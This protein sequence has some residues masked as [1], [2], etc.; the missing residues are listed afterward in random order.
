MAEFKL[1]RIKFVYQGAWTASTSYVVDDVVTVGG[2]S[3]IC[4]ITNTSSSTFATDLNNVTPYWSLMSDGQQ[5]RGNWTNTT[6]YN[7]GDLTQ[8][9]GIVYLC[10]TGHTSAA[11][12]LS[13]TATTFTVS[14]GTA[15]LGFATQSGGAPFVVG[16]TI[17]LAG[18][19]PA[20]TSGSVNTV[21][22]SFIVV[23]CTSTQLTFALTG[24]YTVATLGTVSGTSGVESQI[25][26]W[27]AFAS[28]LNWLG[29]W[30]TSTRYKVD[31]FIYYG[32]I[33]YICN[34]AHVSAS[35][36]ASVG[37]G[38][39][40]N[41]SLWSVFNSGLNYIGLWSGSSVRYKLN[42]IVKYGADLWICTTQHTSTGTTIN[43]SNFTLF[44]NGFEFMNSYSA[45]NSYIIGD[46]VTYGG[47][48]YTCIQNHASGS[49]QTPSTATGYWQIFTTGLNYAG[50][51]LTG[52]SY[53]IG[54]IVTLGGYSYVATADNSA[55]QPPS[56]NWSQLN[57]GI[58]WNAAPQTVYSNVAS[59]N[60]SSS[61]TGSPT[62]TITRN[63]TAYSAV[64]G[65]A[66]GTGY[67]INDTLTITGTVLGGTVANNLVVKVAT[68]SGSAIATV[69]VVSGYAATWKTGIVYV[70]GDAV[71]YGNSSFICVSA[72]IGSTGV[73]DPG[74]DTTATYWNILAGGAD[75][76]VLTTKGDMVYYGTNGPTRLPIGTDGQVLRV[77]N[78]V[79][80]WSYYGLLQN[81]VYVAQNG[82]DASG[83]GQGLTIDK[84]WATLLYACKQI[85]D[86]YLNG[87][88][89]KA[90]TINKQFILK[91]VNTFILT[92]YSFNVTGTAA[93]GNLINV[94]GSSTSSQTTT[95]NMYYGMPI[96]FSA[97][98][99]GLTVGTIYYVNTFP[100]ATTFTVSTSYRSGATLGIVSNSAVA[101]TATFSYTQS[102]AERDAGTILD[103]IT[104]DLTHGGNLYVTNATQQFFKTLTSLITDNAT[105]EV[106]VWIAS[107][108]YM[109]NTLLP[110]VLTNSAPATNYQ[111]LQNIPAANRAI[112]NTTGVT[113][114]TIES[115]SL[116]T[117][118]TLMEVIV[119]ALTAGTYA[120]IPQ[121]NR[122]HTSIYLKTGTYN[123]Y[124][125]IV[126]S[127]DTAI[128]GDELRST[129]V[130]ASTAQPYLGNDK[131]RTVASLKRI[132]ANLPALVSNAPI[133]TAT[134]L[135][136]YSQS[137]LNNSTPSF[138]TA[139]QSIITNSG[140]IQTILSGGLTSVPGYAT[141]SITT[142]LP[143]TYT[144]LGTGT[145]TLSTPTGFG[146][147]LTNTAYSITGLAVS[148]YTGNVTGATTGYDSAVTNIS[149]NTTFLQTE[150]AAYLETYNSGGWTPT[151]W[152]NLST[153]QKG[154]TLR[155]IAYLLQSVK[156]D[157]TYGGNSQ[158]QIDG[159][160]YWSLGNNT[161][162]TAAIIA[163]TTAALTRLQTIIP[164]IINGTTA[165]WTKST[166]NGASQVLSVIGPFANAALYAQAL[167]GN[168]INWLNGTNSPANGGSL[169]TGASLS[170]T[171]QPYYGW[172][173]LAQ[174]NA[175]AAIQQ[176]KT[177]IQLQIQNYVAVTYPNVVSNLALTYRDAGTIVDALSYDMV[178]GT[179]Y[180]SMVSGRAF[181][182]FNTSA[183]TL[184]GTSSGELQATTTSINYITNYLNTITINSGGVQ[185][186]GGDVGNEP[187]VNLVINNIKIIQDMFAGGGVITGPNNPNYSLGLIHQPAFN[188][189]AVSNY[190]TYYLVGYADAKAQ[191]VQ[192]Y[193][194]IKDEI[195]NY[196]NNTLTGTTWA[197]YGPLYQ[198]ETVRDLSS[199]LDALQYDL[200]Y[201]C[202]N[203]ALIVGNSYYSLNTALIVIPYTTGVLAA[204]NR[205]SAI[206]PYVLDPTDNGTASAAS[207]V[208][209]GN[210]T[211]QVTSGTSGSPAA[212]KFA[213][214]RVADIIYFLNNNGFPNT[215]TG[216]TT[217]TISGTTLTVTSGTGL[218]IGQ[219]ITGTTLSTTI[220]GT[221]SNGNVTISSTTGLASGMAITFST[222]Y[223]YGNQFAFGGLTQTTYTINTVSTGV[224]TLYN[225]GTT[226][227]PTLSTATGQMTATAG[228]A[229]GTYI[230]AGSGTSW[231]ISV[232]QTLA[233]TT[234]I[235]GTFVITPVVSGASSFALSANLASF[236]AINDRFN[237]IAADAT[238]WVT[239]F[240][241]N[242]SPSLVLTKR[243]AGY[244]VT[245][246]MYDVLF[247]SNFYSIITGRSYNRLI[248]LVKELHTL[249][250]DST[251]GSIGFIGERVKLL[252]ANGSV[253]QATAVIDEMVATIYGQPTNNA[254]F[255][256]T[257]N[258]TQLT[259]NSI[260][261][262]SLITGMSLS[263][264]GINSGT[265]LVAGATTAIT[266][267]AITSTTGV[268]SCT[269]LTTP[270]VV[271]QQ[272][273]ISGTF[274]AG[275]ISG[276]VS[277]T[278][279]YVIGTPTTTA[280]QL[281]AT[282]GGTAVTSTTSGATITGLTITASPTTWLTNYSQSVSS[283]TTSVVNTISNTN[284][285]TLGTT[286][287]MVPGLQI[288][289][290][291]TAISNLTPGVYYIK[292]VLSVTQLT[293]S[294]TY[295]G[296]VLAV[297]PLNT[298]SGVQITG[299][300]G[301]FSCNAVSSTLTVG[302]PVT[303]SGT[304]GGTGSITGYA[305]PSIY[306]IIATNGS[307][308]FQLSATSNGSAI[309]TTQGQPTGLT[310]T[311][312]A[313]GAMTAVVY[314]IYSGL[315]LTTAITGS[316]TA[317][318]VTAVTTS[319]NL[320]T[321]NSNA[322]VYPNMP[323]IFS[324]LPANITT[325][326]TQT[327]GS[328]TNTITLAA[329]ASSLGIVAGQKIWF[330]GAV[331]GGITLNQLY[332]VINPSGSTIQ[333]A[334]TFGGGAVSLQTSP[335][336]SSVNITGTAG[337][338]SCTSYNSLVVGQAITINGTLSAGTING[339]AVVTAQTYYIIATNGTT[340]FTLSATLGGIAITTTTSGGAITGT[341]FGVNA[342]L[343]VTVNAAG[344]L[345]SGNI[346]WVKDV[347]Q[348]TY[349]NAGTTITVANS[350]KSGI[351]HTITNSL[352]GLTASATIGL[353]TSQYTPSQII[354]GT[355]M[356]G[357]G[358]TAN[359]SATGYNNSL[360]T[361]TGSELLRL[362]KSFLAADAIQ[363]V[364]NTY[365]GTVTT[366]T[367]G[368][369]ITT[370]A[371][372]QLLVGDP[373]QFSGTMFDANI[374]AG[375]IYWVLTAPTTST[376]TITTTQAGTGTQTTLALVGGS[377]SMTV[378]YAIVTTTKGVRD[379]VYHIDALVYDLAKTG[380]YKSLRSVQLY[381]SAQG[382]SA[383]T[384]IFHIQN[385][386]GIRNMTLNGLSGSL[387]LPNTF[388]TRRVSAGAYVG[389]DPGF[390]PNDTSVW[391][392]TRSPYV[393][394]VTNFGNACVGL[395]IDAAL[396]S[397]GNKSI[398]ANDFT[399]VLSDGIGVWAT[400]SGSLTECVSVFCYYGYTAYLSELGGR[401]RATNGNSSYGTYGVIAEGIDSYETPI[402]ATL[403]NRA[404]QAYV[405]NVITDGT[406]QV[407]RLEFQNAGGAYTN[408]V[409]TV[410]GSGYNIVAIQ[411][412][413]RDSAVFETRLVDFNNGQGV[414]GSNYLTIS[415]T[416]QVGAVG[417]I[418][419]ANSDTNLSS[420]YPGMRIQITAGT[421]V[422][423][424]A[425]IVAYG[426][427][428]KIV[429][430]IRPNF[431]PLTI[432][433]NTTSAFTV[434]TNTNTLYAN[435]P[436]YFYTNVGSLALATVYYVVG[437][438]LTNN[439]TT[440]QLA[441]TSGGSAIATLT[442]TTATAA[443]MTQSIIV[444]TALTIN[445]SVTNTIYVGMLLSG[446]TV[447]ANTYITAGSGTSWTVSVSQNVASTT[448]TGTVSVPVY[449]AGWD[450]AIPGA[451]V[452]PILD[453]TSTYTIEPSIAYTSP[454]FKSTAQTL[455]GAGNTWAG[456][457]YGAS[458][459]VA[460]AA[461]STVTSYSTDGK[462]WNVGGV[463]PS[464]T[465]W[466]N[467][468]YGGGQN[469]TATAVVGGVGGS[470]ASLTPV[471]GSG[472]TGGQVTSITVTN[473]GYNYLTPPTIVI[474]D[475]TGTG[476]TAICQVLNGT[477]QSV[478][479]TITG[480]GYT[481]P[482]VTVVTSELTSIT[483]NTWGQNYFTGP[484]VI[485]SAPFT[486][487][488][489][490]SGGTAASG[491]YYYAVDTSVSP[492]VTNYYLAGGSGTFSA[493][494]PTFTN[495]VYGKSG[496]GA[497]G[498]GASATYGI[499]LTYVGT[500]AVATANLTNNGVSSFTITQA[501]YGYSLAPTITVTDPN[502]GFLAISSASTAN[503]YNTGV[504]NT[505]TSVTVASS[506]T[507]TITLASS[508]TL[509][510]NQAITFATSFGN[511]VAGTTYY[512][513]ASISNSSSLQITNALNGTVFTVGTGTSL[514][515]IGTVSALTNL[516][517][518]WTANSN[519][520]PTSTMT[521]VAYGNNLFIAV[522]G[523]GAAA[524]AS[525]TGA[526]SGSWTT[527]SSNITANSSGYTAIAYGGGVFL[528][529]GGTVC[530]GMQS[531]PAQWYSGGTLTS[532]T[533]TG[534]AYGNGRFVALASD[535]TLQYSIN[536]QPGNWTTGPYV[537]NNTWTTVKSNP[538]TATGI[539]T[540]KNIR[541]AEGLFVAIATSSQTVATSW[542]GTDWTVYA[543]TAGMP[544]SSNWTGL[545]FGNPQNA[546]LG[547]VPTWVSVSNTSGTTAASM[548]TGATPQ[549]RVKI[550][551]NQVSE[552]RMIEPGSGF[553]RGNVSATTYYAGTSVQVASSATTTITLAV[554]ATLIQNQAITFATSF[555][556]VTANTT[557][558]VYA[559]T[560]ASTSVQISTSLN[561]SL[562]TVGT[563]TSLSIIGTVAA[564]SLIT[565]DNTTNLVAN[566]PVVF[567]GTSQG[568]I[569]T[570][571]YYY[572]VANSITATQFQVALT[573][574]GSSFTAST[575]VI[576][577]MT[578]FASPITTITDPN[579]VNNANV[580][581]RIG[582]GAL[583]NPTFSNRGTGNTTATASYGGDGYADLYQTGTF[584][585][586]S[587]LFSIP[588]AGCN[589][590]FGSI[591]S[592]WYKLVAVTNQLGIAGNYTATFQI[593]PGISTL[594]APSHN[595]KITTNL[596][597]SNTR[598]TGHDF[599]Y[600][601][602][603]GATSTNYPNVDPTLAVQANQ[604]LATGGGRVFFTS[605]DQDGNF[606]VGNLF[607][608]QQST[609]T[610]TLNASAF[611]LAGLNSLTLGSVSLGVGSATIT[612]FSTDPYFT[613]NS[614][615][616]VP[617][618]KAIKSFITAQIG[619]GQS[620]LN[621]NTITS[622][623]IYIAGNTISNTT[624][625][626]IY[627]SSK[628]LFTGGIDGAPVA[629]AFFGQK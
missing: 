492:N 457:T 415:N 289:I 416:A 511:V 147:S 97:P 398:V 52:T 461:G 551:T 321:I 81:T 156:Y 378:N 82:V 275:S 449:E 149:A 410:S 197:S 80:S 252:A 201:G 419:I 344:G 91:E 391:I 541:Y 454:G 385:G 239:K 180:F 485:V 40:A 210:N 179:T 317:I 45:S 561:G 502:A 610:A 599:L 57:S 291:G 22:A 98:T 480:S 373:V 136:G 122:P 25:N 467:V 246:L 614:D 566:Q 446:G 625:A 392:S 85:E 163:G 161:L 96:I 88:A 579:H 151:V 273:T 565:V 384:D 379:A 137:Y 427:T 290:S 397:G 155:D 364:Q 466:N 68:V 7:P 335:T 28:N 17:T 355:V 174:R 401:I 261:S 479:M 35:T 348:G 499:T 228:V 139:T 43:T 87:N 423:Q 78:N 133:A 72:H 157:L 341:V 429:N 450:T 468:V 225:Y 187:A 356:P 26:N 243:D 9:G 542:N 336:L 102:K 595:V 164:Y 277:G 213:Q 10:T 491:N 428:S 77:N 543:S 287:G 256:G 160:A 607:G 193:Q 556:N 463:L 626:Q 152:T 48:T 212:V 286:A 490:A 51:W 121:L 120:N 594:L 505:A 582:N 402:Y 558:Y 340:T 49:P 351:Q 353:A 363:F 338:F 14:A 6:F 501:G 192:N 496:Y 249:L 24:T 389:F 128:L 111:S 76:G 84:P 186:L 204:L 493:T 388:G 185:T 596:L 534:L 170:G 504:V 93:S 453:A 47:Y 549:G 326:A 282:Q 100:S 258:G 141:V 280:F 383:T 322:G 555:G 591:S 119:G 350:F 620:T 583:G 270:L 592:T 132:Q 295:N 472:S 181:Y 369:T 559:T 529:I 352:T 346:Y 386:T 333:I 362:N 484:T 337:Q 281:S 2:K 382:G 255:N 616:V 169:S 37:G 134:G 598:M 396:H 487:T 309:V 377:G 59:T 452:Q 135:T 376:L 248:P 314:G 572:V 168:V 234:T 331:L 235:T 56:A 267:P 407:L 462:T 332:Y 431:T 101:S 230:T 324:G 399:Q 298:L 46:V 307:T 523:S 587:G 218:A 325:V 112:Q 374:T 125:P 438:S 39:E 600:I 13:I 528:A 459:F 104:F 220:T 190:N 347:T 563:G 19:S 517:A 130:Q 107:L 223:N 16:Q 211:S 518:A 108:K 560:A 207:L 426:A 64:I 54:N 531:N 18:F 425:N 263:G 165:G 319:T 530:S 216:T 584:I 510:Q 349:P 570:G 79:P 334:N 522:G 150:I 601:G 292:Q 241:Q 366:T 61:G 527:Q 38:L 191:L 509:G 44:V 548:A 74:T 456:L 30:T 498:I 585:N 27:T 604:V 327:I 224:I 217:G 343:S 126:L 202:N 251:Y 471:L 278:V 405:T 589:V 414:G 198:A 158:S 184:V 175:F 354:N 409:P 521:S 271:G 237:E 532:K 624:G 114:S 403:N 602:T 231:T 209:S 279:Y 183:Q 65:N 578:Y 371:P 299:T 514:A 489:W 50:A 105:Y 557:Y 99:G 109:E 544:S 55:S 605:T 8:Y 575:A 539:T 29:A 552:V 540:W 303:I 146:S 103:C 316:S 232:S 140:I 33:T 512:V 437:G 433:S 1:G 138:S 421:G 283:T 222:P 629:L 417:I 63:G 597:Y 611:N 294:A 524:A 412:E 194:F 381:L 458:N 515:I 92:T 413:F 623:Q 123:E 306:Y 606:N 172:A 569:T 226:T 219:C 497:S 36:T 372:H 330:T 568:G 546:T 144:A 274:S 451:T 520:L 94:G 266:T 562:F 481:S 214:A 439:G 554:A 404:N 368:G 260:S 247:A 312:G 615:S 178:L 440:F 236:N 188:L 118:Q 41:Q 148:G 199:V 460:T 400:G 361:I 62:F 313:S 444:G 420:A 95:A 276:Y 245:A 131:T 357:F 257:I 272:V 442:A 3:Y 358:I 21:N 75:S 173:T 525:I 422:G 269:A 53:K 612:Q 550:V 359:A 408:G 253:A 310:Y 127:Q 58:R 586:V 475:P 478:T 67:A 567:N 506:A 360:T 547:A 110:A 573:S 117:A 259:V 581:A 424:Y 4:V 293:V 483:A 244:V 176:N 474:T 301:Q 205:L 208:S 455:S 284:Y 621:V 159:L 519:V 507:T 564:L 577:S 296:P 627:V 503:A 395:K 470:G 329:T 411:D 12:T 233:A 285:L 571:T 367:S 390:G 143:A 494:K 526:P 189:P 495:A 580:N 323:V 441:L 242:E 182:R 203:Q 262:G 196:L 308:T 31:D 443:T 250:A 473:G 588:K 288:T 328:S 5:W 436:I 593:N 508:A 342:R 445:G 15:T 345:V 465:T 60:L 447:A 206:L 171:V 590:T 464:S 406:N 609:G 113:T 89:G 73:N 71:Y 486:S 387:G 536:W 448:L 533:W 34:T 393:Q 240:Y 622:G 70:V 516:A 435:Q 537:T 315:G 142:T 418:T 20:S 23:T 513:F 380:N 221:N 302:Q 42:D 90:L 488:P 618:Q 576:S 500:L 394:N 116:T 154:Q 129:I 86:G 574:G 300:N 617:T 153:Q 538:L 476:A 434:S 200:T 318:P 432:V 311:T 430:V 297:T 320:I 603:G 370:T 254:S 69:S 167:I 264:I 265:T 11:S 66:A 365:G 229:P 106:S 545:A 304:F 177:F 83:N 115:G 124:G 553:P 305:S 469:A 145:Q 227:A 375:T 215:T 482:S 628:M 166:N 339:S 619:G 32:G 535:G 477:I 613:A 268:F 238:S 195:T 608:V 162:T